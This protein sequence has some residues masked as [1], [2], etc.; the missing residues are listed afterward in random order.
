MDVR[1]HQ[2]VLAIAQAIDSP[3]LTKDD[4]KEHVAAAAGIAEQSARATSGE[5]YALSA[6]DMKVDDPPFVRMSVK[7]V[8][9]SFRMMVQE[10]AT[11]SS[12]CP[13]GNTCAVP[14]QPQPLP[15][16]PTI[17]HRPYKVRC[18]LCDATDE[19]CACT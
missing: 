15:P 4:M 16:F 19:L 6:V 1:G 11:I 3:P 14:I 9:P 12:M 17:V 5:G 10:G 7:E 2:P 13:S 18:L 8:V